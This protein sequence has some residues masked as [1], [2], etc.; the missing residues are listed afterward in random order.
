MWARINHQLLFKTFS[1]SSKQIH[2]FFF[3]MTGPSQS[4]WLAWRTLIMEKMLVTLLCNTLQIIV[5]LQWQCLLTCDDDVCTYW[6]AVLFCSYR[7]RTLYIPPIHCVNWLQSW[8]TFNSYCL[9]RIIPTD[10]GYPIK[11]P[12]SFSPRCA[13]QWVTRE[14]PMPSWLHCNVQ[15][16]ILPQHDVLFL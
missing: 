5:F 15:S 4:C 14:T 6:C 1:S 10:M 13:S 12:F 9:C 11:C 3:C 2:L 16:D 7:R 8:F